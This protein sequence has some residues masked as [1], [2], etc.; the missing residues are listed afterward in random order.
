MEKR[1][2]KVQ[3][4]KARICRKRG[5][6]LFSLPAACDVYALCRAGAGRKFVLLIGLV[7]PKIIALVLNYYLLNFDLNLIP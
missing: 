6:F 7:R 1:I 2:E 4:E 5:I 3:Q